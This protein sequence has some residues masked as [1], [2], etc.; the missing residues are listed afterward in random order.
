MQTKDQRHSREIIQSAGDNTV[1]CFVPKNPK[2][3]VIVLMCCK[4]DAL[5]G[6]LL[7]LGMY[8]QNVSVSSGKGR[9]GASPVFFHSYKCFYLVFSSHNL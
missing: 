8:L 2:L 7:D 1:G 4:C 6:I 3:L 5:V 9:K